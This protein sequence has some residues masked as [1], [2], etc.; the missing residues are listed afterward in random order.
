MTQVKNRRYRKLMV[1]AALLTTTLVFA[2]FN[3]ATK[4]EMNLN[5]GKL[6]D[7]TSIGEEFLRKAT[8]ALGTTPSKQK[9]TVCMLNDNAT[10]SKINGYRKS[11]GK[12]QFVALDGTE[13][14]QGGDKVDIP[15][16]FQK[17]F[18]I[19]INGLGKDGLIKIYRIPDVDS[20]V[21]QSFKIPSVI[22]LN[23][24][25]IY[26]GR[27]FKIKDAQGNEWYVD[28]NAV[29][30]KVVADKKIRKT[31]STITDQ[32][33]NVQ[34]FLTQK[35]NLTPEELSVITRGTSL[36]GIEYAAAEIE[37]EYGINSLFTLAL[38]AHE[39]GWGN[40]YLARERN[41]LFGIAA[42]DSN[43]G[44]AS[45]YSS[46]SECVRSW[47]RL[48]ANEY[49]AHG[50]TTL[51]SINSIYASDPGWANEVHTQM[52]EMSGKV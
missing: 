26:N 42:Y 37:E 23:E 5:D 36:E 43:V 12:D 15:N 46:K 7:K 31:G 44:S 22:K 49:F 40:S 16:K 4:A 45:S 51:Y 35:T 29:D 39:S 34:L 30:Y 11:V 18:H 13:N 14:I 32:P 50:R 48:I 2:G 52:L 41:N 47:G 20:E 19:E 10:I 27:F 33:R 28:S 1:V 21:I 17:D 3:D 6:H 38:A 25:A 24:M 9:L 8:P